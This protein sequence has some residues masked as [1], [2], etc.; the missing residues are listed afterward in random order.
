MPLLR[1]L[2]G[3]DSR[4]RRRAGNSR[5]KTPPPKARSVPRNLQIRSA[6]SRSMMITSAQ[7]PK[8][9]QAL[10][11]N[12]RRHRDREGLMLVEGFDELLLA[13]ES[14]VRP[15]TLCYC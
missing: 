13:L 9:K 14:G 5:I 10:R 12:E 1:H 15:Q 7:N 11:L 6:Q 4:P 8:I 3:G 2:G